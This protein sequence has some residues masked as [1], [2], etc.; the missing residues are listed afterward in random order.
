MTDVTDIRRA[1][2][3]YKFRR[4]K[5]WS[6]LGRVAFNFKNAFSEYIGVDNLT[7]VDSD[8]KKI[9][10]VQIGHGRD[11]KFIAASN[12]YDNIFHNEGLDLEFI[13]RI[14]IDEDEI[15]YP[16]TPIYFSFTISKEELGYNLTYNPPSEGRD[17]DIKTGDRS[18]FSSVC[19]SL[20]SDLVTMFEGT[21]F[22]D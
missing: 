8:G 6:D 3:D 10:Y 16:K 14:V 22:P 21:L 15:V 18:S 2:K 19:E 20:A 12:P 13:V 4:D 7:Y 11:G 17:F 9:E 1:Y 5:H